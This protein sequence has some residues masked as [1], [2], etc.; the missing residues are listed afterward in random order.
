MLSS[1]SL[2]SSFAEMK[3]EGPISYTLSAS[4]NGARIAISAEKL[5]V[6]DMR[7]ILTFK[8]AGSEHYFYVKLAEWGRLEL[9]THNPHGYE[10]A[11]MTMIVD[12]TCSF[13]DFL[14]E[15]K[16]VAEEA[17]KDSLNMFT[18]RIKYPRRVG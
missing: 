8:N 15:C 9:G 16:V 11:E 6:N 1:Y 12:I 7:D 17:A 14:K 13:N 2:P 18:L 10:T 5:I 4:C 3:D